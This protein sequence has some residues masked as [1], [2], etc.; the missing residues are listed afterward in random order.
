[1]EQV[2]KLETKLGEFF[3][4]LPALPKDSKEA[5]V[6]A[7]PWIALVFGVLQVAAAWGLWGLVRWSDRV[8]NV[9]SS[10]YTAAGVGYSS[11]ERMVIYLALIVLL[12]DGVILLMAFPELKKRSR[13]GW[14]LL[15]IGALLNALYSVVSIFIDA[16]GMS[17]LVMGALSTAVGLYL[18]YQVREKYGSTKSSHTDSK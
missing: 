12:V 8:V 2:H 10:Y 13:R 9:F 16:R 14:D 1:M 17:S 11:S 5:L 6:K 18:L 3:K 7:W 15:F 4:P